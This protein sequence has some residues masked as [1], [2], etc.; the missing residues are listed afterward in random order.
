MF[1]WPNALSNCPIYPLSRTDVFTVCELGPQYWFLSSLCRDIL[2]LCQL[3]AM[4]DAISGKRPQDVSSIS[5]PAPKRMRPCDSAPYKYRP[6]AQPMGNLLFSASARNARS[7]G[8]GSLSA[9][10]D[11][12][13]S[14]IFSE[15]GAAD[16]LRCQATSRAFF[17]WS[18]IEGHW[19]L[20]FIKRSRGV[21]KDW[22]GSWRRTYIHHFVK[23]RDVYNE[24]G[25]PSDAIENK[26]IFSDV[27]YLPTL[28]ANYAADRICNSS[29]FSNNIPRKDGRTVSNLAELD[30]TPCILT[31]LMDDW[32][33]LYTSSDS[34]DR[35][36]TLD[37]LAS[38]YPETAFR[39]EAV[40]TSMQ[41]YKRYHDSCNG[42][43]SPLYIFDPDFV[44][45]TSTEER[46]RNGGSVARNGLGADFR[47]PKLFQDDLFKVLGNERPNFRWLVCQ[48]SS[49][50]YCKLRCL[51][52][53]FS[54]D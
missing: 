40:L 39:A 12:L 18:S 53:L 50:C 45:K 47:V 16:Y 5:E 42:D 36:W 23:P 26:D 34:T 51:D 54:L 27:L 6:L 44:E 10:P 28:A 41:D 17:A 43:E 49:R 14:A 29:S 2:L 22:K 35:K 32:A 25:L 21:L 52:R 38:R 20:E 33:S 24:D 30:D 9:L 13:V 19:K 8:L 15:L 3:H 37:S 4:V 48:Y 31:H 1:T 46:A 7:S 11:E